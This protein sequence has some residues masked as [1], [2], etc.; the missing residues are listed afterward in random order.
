S[1]PKVC[2]GTDI[3]P[4]CSRSCDRCISNPTCVFPY[5]IEQFTITAT[6]YLSPSCCNWTIAWQESARNSSITTGAANHDFYMEA[7]LNRC[8]TPC[9]SSP[10]FTN[11][12]VAIFCTNQCIVYNPGV[13][14]N[15]RDAEGRADSLAYSFGY[16]QDKAGSNI[17]Y[18]YPYSND[19]PLI[20]AGTS[21]TQAFTPPTCY[22]FHLDSV[23]GDL[24]FKAI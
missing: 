21:K 12:P 6:I 5:G 14:D 20:Y 2:C 13:D 22:G 8:I 11:P 23:T 15:S 19:A 24:E 3:T 7:Q 9:V 17:P 4:V 10:Y 1:N 18:D 16:P